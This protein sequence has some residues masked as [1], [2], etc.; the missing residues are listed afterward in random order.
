MTINLTAAEPT[1]TATGLT[2]GANYSIYHTGPIRA[3]VEVDGEPTEVYSCDTSGSTLLIGI[4]GT[5]IT[6]TLPP[7]E[8]RALL[9]LPNQ[10]AAEITQL[11]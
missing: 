4:P 2:E 6:L 3:S 7:A 9:N 5:S 1:A 11:A 10:A 8:T